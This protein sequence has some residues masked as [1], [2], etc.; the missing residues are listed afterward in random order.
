M[1]D[2]AYIEHTFGIYS[3]Y[4]GTTGQPRGEKVIST[5]LHIHAAGATTAFI[6]VRAGRRAY[7]KARATT[8]PALVKRYALCYAFPKN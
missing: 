7:T 3:A 2:G 4:I 8:C 5:K 6:E 1:S